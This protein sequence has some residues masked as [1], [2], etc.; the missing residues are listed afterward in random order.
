MLIIWNLIVN[1]VKVTRTYG[2]KYH[3]TS[4]A[5]LRIFWNVS[6]LMPPLGDVTGASVMLVTASAAGLS[7]HGVEAR[8]RVAS[9]SRPAHVASHCFGS[10]ILLECNCGRYFRLCFY[11]LL[12]WGSKRQDFVHCQTKSHLRVYCLFVSISYR[13]HLTSSLDMLYIMLIF[14]NSYPIYFFYKIF[15]FVIVSIK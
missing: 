1:I 15:K 14:A 7:T 5:R 2:K 4:T 8:S 10:I 9:A 13:G 3:G 11:A 12:N 6:K